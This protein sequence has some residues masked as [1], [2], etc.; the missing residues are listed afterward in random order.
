MHDETDWD[1]WWYYQDG[2]WFL[3]SYC[4]STGDHVAHWKV[5][6]VP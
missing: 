3:V 4:F 1:L 5:P 6:A 2:Y